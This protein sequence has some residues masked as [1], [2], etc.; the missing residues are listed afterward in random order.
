[1]RAKPLA[2]AAL[3][4][5]L[6]SCASGESRAQDDALANV[7]VDPKFRLAHEGYREGFAYRHYLVP[8]EFV[9]PDAVTP[10]PGFRR[11]RLL[12]DPPDI[13]DW[14]KVAIFTDEPEGDS[15]K[16]YVF[17]EQATD[18]RELFTGLTERQE[19]RVIAGELAL[20]RLA[21]LCGDGSENR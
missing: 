20:V 6:T 13:G 4:L 2:I 17:V 8:S 11:E 19:E 21:S 5:M 15:S 18:V 12:E 16:C 7:K 3:L 10:P 14:K 1:M 9:G